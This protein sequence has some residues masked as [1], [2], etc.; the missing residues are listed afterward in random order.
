MKVKGKGLAGE[1][2][3]FLGEFLAL[4]ASDCAEM[5]ALSY[6]RA[7]I[8]IDTKCTRTCKLFVHELAWPVR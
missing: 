7:Q 3:L 1:S 8:K 4:F 5:L 2:A 6:I